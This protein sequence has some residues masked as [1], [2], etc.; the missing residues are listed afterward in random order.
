MPYDVNDTIA[1][2]ASAAG[3]GARGVIRISGP[4]ALERLARCFVSADPEA[5]TPILSKRAQRIAGVIN[6]P[7]S[8]SGDLI[9]VPGK[10]LVWPN[11]QSYT[12][13]PAAE[14]HT[15]GSPPLVAAVLEE[16]ER[17]GVRPA[18]PGEFTL[19][20]FVAGR[21]DLMQAEGVLGVIDAEGRADLD[22]A[23]DQVAGGM[24]RPLHQIREDLLSLLA[25][26]EAGLDFVEEDI[27]FIG[28][29]ELAAR[30]AAAQQVVSATQAQLGE[31]DRRREL[32][33]VV[34]LGLPNAG[35]SSLFNALVARFGVG[36]HGVSS[37]V[38]PTPGATRDYVV[39]CVRLNGVDVELID[40]AGIEHELQTGIGGESQRATSLQ[41]RSADVRL[42]CVD[43]ASGVAPGDFA[44][45]EI[46]VH[47]K[48]DLC[49]TPSA[50]EAG[51]ASCPTIQC[52]STTGAGL[53]ELAAVIAAQ[54]TLLARDG[55]ASGLTASTATRCAGSLRRA[56][57][58][59][60]VAHGLVMSGGDE[61]LAA[62][63][64]HALDALGEIVGAIC[65]DDVL[66]RVFSQFCIGK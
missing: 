51:P 3:G 62:E 4:Q 12:R 22:A 1:A 36:E 15:I 63:I 19:R 6:V 34:L 39:G 27:E 58:S 66:D 54:V 23:L 20:A 64:R 9:A 29:D 49:G 8:F 47:T 10:L 55:E 56:A 13:Q 65:T 32:P 40:T 59:L 42:R 52:S 48:C 45:N 46:A 41:Q 57:A 37:I 50:V 21:I 31:R 25:E 24:S 30:I 5:T 61:L 43:G 35:K 38:S 44:G 7:S 33:R 2:I 60:A 11:Q 26:L 14:F 18:E 16:L 17:H 53:D 28:R